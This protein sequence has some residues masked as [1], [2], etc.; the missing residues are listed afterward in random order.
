M[1]DTNW[2]ADLTRHS[3]PKYLA[4]VR[5][6][7]EGIRNGALLPGAK[8]PTVR[9]LAYS[10]GV[11]PGTVARGYQIAT[12]EGL[13]E[14]VVGRGTFV[15]SQS[16]RLGPTEAIYNLPTRDPDLDDAIVDLR[17]PQLPDIG[18]TEALARAMMKAAEGIGR[19][20]L[21]YPGLKRDEYCRRAAL[22]WFSEYT[23]FDTV[24]PDDLVLTHGG[25]NGIMMVMQCCLRG[26]RPVIYAEALAY[27][28]FRH[29]AR[30]N[31]AE[32]R[33][34][35]IDDEGMVPEALDAACRRYG[36]QLI[37][38]TPDAQNPT[39]GRMG[40]ERRHALI[41]VARRH[42]LQIIEDD[43]YT[44]PV[45][46][47]PSLRS[48]APERCW[49]VTSLSKS[50]SAGMRFG[51]VVAPDGMGEAGRLTAQHSYFGLSRPVT[52]MMAHLFETGEALDLK[53]RAQA[54]MGRRLQMLLQALG[55]QELGWQSGLSFVW[56]TLPLGWRASAF[57]RMAEAEGVLLRAA[58][59]YALQDG[60]APNA[61]RI[62]LAGGVSE[63]RFRQAI[64]TLKHLLERM[65]DELLV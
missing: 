11:T 38:V 36:G 29:A 37:C 25:Q 10:L 14:A 32:I 65:P 7:R 49:H 43:C 45:T 63:D 34:I 62:A 60:Q 41:A 42:D 3:G 50:I 2:T 40:I 6:L 1:T 27:P 51:I 57:A 44:A 31:R 39:A 47:L 23:D 20:Y 13:L 30:L 54:E 17:S 8:L 33:G 22:N 55:D 12:Q 52:D 28:G 5:A 21:E 26:E 46:G 16:R 58:D 48:L 24:T 64:E 59:E 53:A 18:Q 9:D 35:A 61:V 19:Q 4:L 15:S 56:L